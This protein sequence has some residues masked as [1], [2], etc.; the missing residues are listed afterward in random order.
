[1]RRV[2]KQGLYAGERRGEELMKRTRVQQRS[3]C[4]YMK[5][6]IEGY[7]VQRCGLGTRWEYWLKDRAAQQS[8]GYPDRP[9]RVRMWE[10]VLA[11]TPK[12]NTVV[13]ANASKTYAD[14]IPKL[15]FIPIH[16]PWAL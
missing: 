16:S 11:L 12:P 1:M 5:K 7:A 8:H 14:G 2:K 3:F 9:S 10:Q 6:G 4:P 13:A 15:E